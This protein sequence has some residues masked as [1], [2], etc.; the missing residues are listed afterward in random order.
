MAR[1][2]SIAVEG[3]ADLRR[4]LRAINSDL[5]GEL[6]GALR[7]AADVVAGQARREAPRRTG[8]LAASIRPGTSGA[9][10]MV[11]SPLP[12]AGPIHWGWPQQGIR[13]NP[14]IERAADAK[15]PAALEQLADSVEALSIRHGFNR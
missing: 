3:L 11:R 12:Y 4:D 14:F 13:A 15:A 7:D 9:R 2:P 1:R 6:R 5:P 8:R 10:A